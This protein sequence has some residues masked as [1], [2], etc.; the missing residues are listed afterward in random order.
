MPRA[1]CSRG[2]HVVHAAVSYARKAP[3]G[4]RPMIPAVRLIRAL[5]LFGTILASYFL[6]FTVKR[7]VVRRGAGTPPWLQSRRDRIDTS[8]ARR[9]LAGM[10]RLRGVYIK[11]G[12][13]LSVIGGFLPRAFTRELASLQ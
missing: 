9:L 10:L 11:L 2:A 8:S 1:R 5:W 4:G 7:L 13:V 6:Y 12:Q 3:R